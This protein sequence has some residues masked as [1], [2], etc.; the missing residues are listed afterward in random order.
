VVRA[1]WLMWVCPPLII[2]SAIGAGLVTFV[3]PA[4][5]VRPA[6]VMWFLFACPGL[7]V[8]RFIR[9]ADVVVEWM[10]VLTLS[11]CIDACIAGIVLYAHW[12]SPARILEILIAF[13]LI[14]AVMQF[15]VMLAGFISSRLKRTRMRSSKKLF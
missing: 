2:I 9:L 4:T 15:V 5:G 3:F 1:S 7:A 6:V 14:G 11:L 8:V 10:L 12:W 13:C